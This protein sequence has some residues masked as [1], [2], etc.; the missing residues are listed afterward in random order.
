M[1]RP[2]LLLLDE[3]SLGLAPRDR[4]ADHGDCCA[5]CATSTGPDGP[6][7][8]AERPQRAVGR[9]P[10]RRAQPRPRRRR[11]RRRRPRR[12][13][14]SSATPTWGSEPMSRFL[15]LTLNGSANGAI[16]AA[17]ALSLV[18]IWRATRI[19]NFAQGG[20]ADV[21]DVHRLV[22]DRARRV[23]LGRLRRRAGRRASCSARVVERVLVRPVEGAPPLNAV[24]VTLGLLIAARRRWPGMIWGG[25]PQLVPAARSRSRGYTVG[26]RTVLFSPVDLFIVLVGRGRRRSRSRCCSAAPRSACACARRRSSPRSPGCS[27]CASAGC[28]PSAGRSRRSSARWPACSSRRRCSSRPNNFDAVLVFGFTAAVI[29]GLDSPAGAVVG[30]LL[31]GLRAELRRRATSGADA[32]DARRAG[33]PRRRAHGPAQRA[34]RHGAGQAG[35][36]MAARSRPPPRARRAAPRARPDAAAPPADRARRRVR[37]CSCS[38]LALDAVQQPAA[39]DDRLLL[40]RRRGPDRADRAQRADL[41]RPRRAD[42]DRRLHGGS[43]S[44]R[45]T[46]GRWRAVL[47]AA[48]RRHRGGRRRCVGAAAARLRGPTSPARR[49]RSPSA[50]RRSRDHFPELPRRRNGLQRARRRRRRPRSGATS[51]SSAGRRGS[52]AWPR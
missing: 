2:R 31:L 17:V 27:A 23:L 19:L 45:P 25:N 36:T 20:D 46:A 10:R 34:V 11:R 9:R 7:R 14:R 44:A 48:A 15:D 13:R 47:V 22:G 37:R 18:L 16:Y 52:P 38:T 5:S 28:S 50:C 6:A 26:G 32:G 39:G 29:G 33:D 4:R 51:R 35:L 1:A 12:R 41:A 49:W 42:G 43:S 8:R 40:R 24:I 30:G 3:P 21:H